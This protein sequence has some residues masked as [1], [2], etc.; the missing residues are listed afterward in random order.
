MN[1]ISIITTLKILFEKIWVLAICG[2][3]GLTAGYGYINFIVQPTYK[4]SAIVCAVSGSFLND[5]DNL[6]NQGANYITTAE[7]SVTLA[8]M[9]SFIGIL[10]NSVDI[11]S[12]TLEQTGLDNKYR[13]TQ[14]MGM[15]DISLLKEE[16]FLIKIDVTSDNP[17]D[18]VTLVNKFVELTP[19]HIM[20]KV[21]RTNVTVLTNADVH[22]AKQVSPN[23][24]LTMCMTLLLGVV[25]GAVIVIISYNS[26]RTIKGE[27]DYLAHF[28]LP[29]L[30][31]IPDFGNY[32]TKRKGV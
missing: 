1:E 13:V 8:L 3:I 2:I 12:N 26:D 11:Y 25:V 19:N 5:D 31:T 22:G 30:G 23:V 20:E 15:V 21:G 9:N 28:N 24:V 27:D 7:L 17:Q 10:D 18:C 32:Q 14:L 6:A 29:L 16:T 4:A